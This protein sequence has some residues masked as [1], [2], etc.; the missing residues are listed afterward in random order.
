MLE[1]SLRL[2]FAAITIIHASRYRQILLI[3]SLLENEI[4][5]DNGFLNISVTILEH[6]VFAL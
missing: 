2:F 6:F 3:W 4:Y 5:G 1:K